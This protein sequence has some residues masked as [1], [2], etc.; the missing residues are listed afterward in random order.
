MSN[1]HPNN[2]PSFS[3]PSPR[4]IRSANGTPSPDRIAAELEEQKRMAANSRRF[5]WLCHNDPEG[6]LEMLGLGKG[7]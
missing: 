1:K 2:G 7:N 5:S 6:A 4:T 3:K